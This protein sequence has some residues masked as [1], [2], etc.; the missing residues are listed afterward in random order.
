MPGV[1]VQRRRPGLHANSSDSRGL[2][3]PSC[4]WYAPLAS[5]LST[6]HTSNV[7][8]P[9]LRLSACKPSGTCRAHALS[10]CSAGSVARSGSVLGTVFAAALCRQSLETRFC[11]LEID[12]R[13]LLH[14][15]RVAE[16]TRGSPRRHSR[17]PQQ[18]H[19]VP[20][21]RYG[22][23]LMCHGQQTRVSPPR[24]PSL[25]LTSSLLVASACG[26]GAHVCSDVQTL[27]PKPN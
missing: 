23:P 15:S 2:M 17:Q 4:R 10:A 22:E 1:C 14:R 19:P 25:L 13:P 8:V 21:E 24:M 5:S 3:N 26:C 6:T 11:S 27:N 7:R 20:A 9:A 12:S 18:L 16:D